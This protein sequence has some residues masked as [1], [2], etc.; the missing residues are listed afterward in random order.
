[1]VILS[2]S[3]ATLAIQSVALAGT[4]LNLVGT[5]RVDEGAI[6]AA[7]YTGDLDD[8]PIGI[9]VYTLDIDTNMLTYVE[10]V[11]CVR[12]A[13][14]VWA[15][16]VEPPTVAGGAATYYLLTAGISDHISGAV[17]GPRVASTDTIL[18]AGLAAGFIRAAS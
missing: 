18:S 2:I 3:L 4:F 14:G 9:R 17:G 5:V 6:V 15:Y 8:L 16:L 13:R 1:M 12:A 11:A 7:G 10:T